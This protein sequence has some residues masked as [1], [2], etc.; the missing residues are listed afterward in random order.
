GDPLLFRRIL[1][2]VPEA[3]YPARRPSPPRPA[4][5]AVASS[6]RRCWRTA[7]APRRPPGPPD[8]SFP[9]SPVPAPRQ[10]TPPWIR[11]WPGIALPWLLPVIALPWFSVGLALP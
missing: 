1:C 2:P 10:P 9:P 11:R 5:E 8:L 3:S 7:S 6:S 4:S